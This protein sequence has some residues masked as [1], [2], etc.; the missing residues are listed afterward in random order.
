MRSPAPAV[1]QQVSGAGATAKWIGAGVAIFVVLLWL[2]S[3]LSNEQQIEKKSVAQDTPSSPSATATS[4]SPQTSQAGYAPP[5]F[6]N[7]ADG[8][9]IVGQDVRPGTYRTRVGSPGCY[10]AR[11]AGFGG[12]L[13]ETIANE[14]TDAPAVVTIS[15]ADKGFVSKGCGIWSQDLSAI[16]SNRSTLGDGIYII[17]IDIQPGTYRNN[18]QQGCYYERLRGFGGVL[19]DIIANESADSPAVVTI[20]PTDKGFRS[21]RCGIWSLIPGAQPTPQNEGSSFPSYQTPT[22]TLD[23]KRAGPQPTTNENGAHTNSSEH[24]IRALLNEWTESFKEKDLARQVECYAP[25]M[26]TYFLRHNVSR[27]FVQADKSRA[28][29][30]ITETRAFEI[31]DITI[32]F[33]SGSNATVTFRKKWDTRLA[34]GKTFAGEEI[35]QLQLANIDGGWKITSEKEVQILKVQGRSSR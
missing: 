12:T 6:P 21:S 31:S 14:N 9:H 1:P 3:F 26:D 18:G 2:A 8:T 24:D 35:E 25:I 11:L 17:E 20:S 28:F 19:G 10:Y 7:F 32:E 27:D 29:N 4:H 22:P 5:G 16:T 34:S 23:A 15:S 33:A 13:G 30:A